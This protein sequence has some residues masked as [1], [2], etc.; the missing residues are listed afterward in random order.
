MM[1]SMTPCPRC[2]EM[3]RRAQEAE[4]KAAKAWRQND[5]TRLW[6][7][8]GELRRRTNYYRAGKRM[9]KDRWREAVTPW[10]QR[11]LARAVPKRGGEK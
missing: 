10:W 5:L 2:T 1:A 4:S 7:T 6:R 3:H 9:W 8:V 11:I